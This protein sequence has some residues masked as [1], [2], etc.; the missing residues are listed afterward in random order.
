MAFSSKGFQNDYYSKIKLVD[1]VAKLYMKH[2]IVLL[3][4]GEMRKGE[5]YI[6]ALVFFY[7]SLVFMFF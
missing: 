6:I 3:C 4:L 2:T 5:V 1:K 7:Q